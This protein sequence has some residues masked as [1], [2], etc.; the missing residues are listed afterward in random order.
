MLPGSRN[1]PHVTKLVRN[2]D[3]ATSAEFQEQELQK[4]AR[5]T[6]LSLYQKEDDL[7]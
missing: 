4:R 7:L 1:D 3:Y 2:E 5:Q 6:M